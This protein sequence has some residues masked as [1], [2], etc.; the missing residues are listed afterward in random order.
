MAH[1][2]PDWGLVGPKQTVYGLDDVGEAAVRLGSIVSWDRRGDVVMMDDF[3]HGVGQVAL[4][5]AGLNSYVYLQTGYGK[6]GAYCVRL[7]CDKIIG[8]TC[9]LYYSFPVLVMSGWGLEFA[10]SV[11]ENTDYWLMWITYYDGTY[12][13]LAQIE[14][15]VQNNRL[16]YLDSGNNLQEFAVDVKLNPMLRPINHAKLVVDMTT[17]QYERF[18]LNETT[19]LLKGYGV[20]P[21][22]D[23][24][25][26]MMDAV[27]A[28]YSYDDEGSD[29]VVDCVIVTQ[30]EP[31]SP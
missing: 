20:Y 21:A 14:I 26:P 31:M 23:G 8:A 25:N 5:A 11:E 13:H 29:Q 3:E 17:L 28:V 18:I 24:L 12:S 1:G 2:L 10:F 7:F 22:L 19:Y 30:N 15:D 16:R 9:Q 6:Y 27:M 4:S